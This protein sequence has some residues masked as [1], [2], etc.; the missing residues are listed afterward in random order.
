M[1]DPVEELAR[2][3]KFKITHCQQLR[4]SI[5]REVKAPKGIGGGVAQLKLHNEF[6]QGNAEI[7]EKRRPHL[8]FSIIS[9][10][11]PNR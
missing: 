6:P 4:L 1:S 5:F 8:F 7:A 11:R 9:T 10:N 3:V 2:I